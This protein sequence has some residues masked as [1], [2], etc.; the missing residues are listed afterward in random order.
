MRFAR[1]EGLKTHLIKHKG[2][3]SYSCG[4]CSKIFK[5][6]SSVSGH[7]KT[8]KVNGFYHCGNCDARF[9]DYGQLKSHFSNTAH[10]FYVEVKDEIN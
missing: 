5:H 8:H 7:R 3:W 1:Y 4:I 6:S 10:S 2:E 9:A